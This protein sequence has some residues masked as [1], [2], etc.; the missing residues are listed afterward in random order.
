MTEAFIDQTRLQIDKQNGHVLIDGTPLE[1][2]INRMD[3]RLWHI[4]KDH[5]SY[6]V[7][8]QKIDREART[9]TLSINGK[10][11]TVRIQSRME[12]LLKDLG[13]DSALVRKLDK[14]KAPMPGLIHSI[15]VAEGTEVEKGD[16]LLIL[17]AMK[18][19]N[20]IKSPG[21]G[22]VSKIHVVEKDSVEKN[23]LLISFA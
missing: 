10:K 1:A 3:D 5:H 11:T 19:E 23:E 16:P 2:D 14:L 22:T 9:V 20:V 12:K 18:M 21:A 15:E 17:E 13:M 8:V 4:L 7:F 6:N